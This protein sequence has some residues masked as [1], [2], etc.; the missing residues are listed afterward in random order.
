MI[1][2]SSIDNSTIPISI[3]EA[4]FSGLLKE[5]DPNEPVP[6][7]WPTTDVTTLAIMLH[8][9]ADGTILTPASLA[10]ITGR[11]P[12]LEWP[13]TPTYTQ[14]AIMHELLRLADFADVQTVVTILH[15]GVMDLLSPAQ[16]VTELCAL[17]LD[18]KVWASLSPNE[19]AEV[20]EHCLVN[21]P[22]PLRKKAEL[23]W[24]FIVA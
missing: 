24:T 19:E 8:A 14:L 7:P 1:I 9:C 10:A 20:V 6:L 3:N 21:L 12:L 4:S 22:L 11:V 15:V 18:P 5:C 23:K 17:A 16:T 2:L 13:T